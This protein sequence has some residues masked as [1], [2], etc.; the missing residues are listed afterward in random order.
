MA[1][2]VRLDGYIRVSQVR[3][4][5]GERFIS[6]SVQR[7]RVQAYAKAQ[8]HRIIRFHED[9]DLPG[10]HSER[11][12]LQAALA[13]IESGR[14]EGLIVARLDRFGRSVIDSAQNLRRIQDAG[15]V[16]MS[17]AEGID[18]S[19]PFGRFLANLMSAL[20]ELELD[21]IRENWEVARERAVARGVH[22]ASRTPTGYERDSNGRL[23]RGEHAAAIGRLFDHAAAG[24]S[25]KQ[26][27]KLMADVPT[28][29]GGSHWNSRSLQHVLTNRAYLGEAR[30][31]EFVLPGA[32]PALVSDETWQAAQRKPGRRSG[33]SRSLLA[34][35]L[36]CAGC[37]Y[38]M[39]PDTMRDRSGERVRSYRCRG[40]R[41][42]GTCEARAAVLGSVVE[43][44]V[45]ERFFAKIGDL[46][47]MRS[48]RRLRDLAERKRQAQAELAKY[49]DSEAITILGERDFMDGLATRADTLAAIEAEEESLREEV[50]FASDVV[51]LRERWD[52]LAVEHQRHLLRS[53]IDV[54]FVRKT[55]QANVP[56]ADRGLILWR[57]EG[58]PALPGPGRKMVELRPFDWT[59]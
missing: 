34:G 48:D 59:S 51:G 28:P 16:L 13:R 11:P 37:R 50:G 46:E 15:G 42:M 31:G 1:R 30:S 20:A 9:L 40:A 2:T 56:I 45:V 41:A 53:A 26:L 22:V 39:K 17:V 44:W 3:G 24:A 25:W 5:E 49:R 33:G 35:I 38:A 55:G 14:T 27:A 12:G 8:D 52:D 21:R 32:H 6:P 47:G 7:Q 23:V 29:Y 19:G 4:R 57:G 43:P 36:R 58:P 18:T 10:S 54:V